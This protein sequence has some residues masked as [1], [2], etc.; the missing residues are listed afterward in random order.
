MN[1][2]LTLTAL[3]GAATLTAQAQ[4]LNT[5]KLDSL[6]TSLATNNKMMGS[7]AVSRNGQVVYSHGFGYAQLDAKT[8]ATP[9]TPSTM[10]MCC[11][12]PS[13]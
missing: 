1:A 7:L 3:L 13:G 11:K 2:R 9:A 5:A 4:Q 10:P 6:L 8:P 12:R